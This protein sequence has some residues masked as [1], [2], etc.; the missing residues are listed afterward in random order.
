MNTV[1]YSKNSCCISSYGHICCVTEAEYTGETGK[2]GNSHSGNGVDAEK[3]NYPFS[4][5]RHPSYPLY[6]FA[7][8]FP[9]KTLGTDKQG[10]YQK[11]KNNDI[12]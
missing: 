1:F 12:S 8:V 5:A 11:G 2:E 3:D 7:D 9:E 10:Y 6:L 4:I